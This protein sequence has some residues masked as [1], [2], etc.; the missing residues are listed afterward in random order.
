MTNSDNEKNLFAVLVTEMTG[1]TPEEVY[2][3]FVKPLNINEEYL[4]TGVIYLSENQI[5]TLECPPDFSLVLSLA[6]NH[7]KMNQLIR[8]RLIQQSAKKSR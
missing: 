7:M 3:T 2:N 5:N 6:V 4:D 8:K 1:A